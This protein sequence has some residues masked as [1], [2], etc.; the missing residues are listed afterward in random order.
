[1]PDHVPYSGMRRLLASGS[2]PQIL[3]RTSAS[4]LSWDSF[5]ALRLPSEMSPLETWDLLKLVNRAT[6]IELP[7][8][9]LEGNEYWYLRTHEIADSCARIQCLCRAD[10]E[11]YRRLTTMQNRRVI[12]RSRVDETIAAALLDGL[13]ISEDDA[14][15]LLQTER[16]P[17]S[18]TERLVLNTLNA[19]D[20][21]N[22]LVEQPF[23]LGLF[24]HMRDLIIEGVNVEKLAFTTPRM[25]LM[26]SDYT[27]EQVRDASDRQLDYMIAYA[28]HDAGDVH[29]SVILRGLLLADMFRFYRPLPNM[30]SEVGRLAFRLYTLKT[31]LPVLGMLPLSR[32]KLLWEEG[33]LQS[34]LVTIDKERYFEMRN[35]DGADL[36]GYTTL[37]SQ[38]TL[39]TL[40]E[41]H[42]QLHKLEQRDEELRELLQRDPE[43]NHRQRSILG[44]ALRNPR[45]EFRISYHK[46]T[47][48]VVY[49]TARADLLELVDKGFLNV[50][51]RGRAMVFTPR[52]GLRAF[53]EGG[54]PGNGTRSAPARWTE[55]RA[56][57]D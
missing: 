17:R 28:N 15:S 2:V 24:M 4:Y 52:E 6:G 23:S 41:L 35:H 20:Q 30:N 12:V 34:S 44:R 31:G 39:A 40:Q 55:G 32:I 8:P 53:I 10:S 56:G 27:D 54:S 37:V 36:T 5:L 1:M 46:T 25:G 13:A 11:L 9:D 49:A 33:T 51:K 26:T 57:S 42:W 29:D 18:D 47:H 45:A 22:E 21:L 43:I 38:M 48:N 16:T 7:I 19:L 3:K 14:Y 50:D